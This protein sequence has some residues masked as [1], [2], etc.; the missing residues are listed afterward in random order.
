MYTTI[1]VSENTRNMLKR[2]GY[3][4]ETY[5]DIIL[6]LMNVAEKNDFFSEQKNILNKEKFFRVEDL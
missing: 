1:R 3:K 2:F 5:D 6:N 4:E